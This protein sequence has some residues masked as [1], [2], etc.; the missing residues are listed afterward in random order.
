MN[1]RR[2]FYSLHIMFSIHYNLAYLLG[3]V[4]FTRVFTIRFV[5]FGGNFVV[6]DKVLETENFP[7]N[8]TIAARLLKLEMQG[9]NSRKCVEVINAEDRIA[10][11]NNKIK[12]TPANFM[13]NNEHANALTL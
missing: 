6:Y 10:K 12:R 2:K 7:D 8:G 5:T 3:V 1:T 4:S 13:N 11:Q 9:Y